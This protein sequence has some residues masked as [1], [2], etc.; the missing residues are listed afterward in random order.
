LSGLQTGGSSN[1]DVTVR[2]FF[3]EVAVPG[4]VIMISDFL[5]EGD[6]SGPL[7]MLGDEG[8]ELQL[9]HVAGPDDVNPPWDGELELIDAES[10][11]MLRVQMDRD[12]AGQY[13]EAYGRHCD[14]IEECALRSGGRYLHLTTELSVEDALYGALRQTGSVTLH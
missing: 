2:G 10:G 6:C 12:S 4:L 7:R 5:D 13:A 3:N 14:R 8:H 11:N 1:F 9:V